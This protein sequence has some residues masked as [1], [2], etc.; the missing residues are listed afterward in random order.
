[1]KYHQKVITGKSVGFDMTF[2]SLFNIEMLFEN[3]LK[4]SSFKKIYSTIYNNLV[5]CS[6]SKVKDKFD[7]F[8]EKFPSFLVDITDEVDGKLKK[9]KKLI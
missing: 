8:K 4:N 9:L 5:C 7:Y 2:M 6:S 1:M 3:D